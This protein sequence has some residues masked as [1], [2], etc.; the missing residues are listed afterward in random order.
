MP[1]GCR[2][3]GECCIFFE[4]RGRFP[5]HC[6]EN[7]TSSGGAGPLGMA[8]E[9][10]LRADCKRCQALCCIALSFERSSWF[11]FDKAADVPCPHLLTT[12]WTCSIHS[13]LE[14]RGQSGC[15]VYDCYG[16][17]QR[18]TQ[19]LP[20]VRATDGAG[21]ARRLT[22]AFRTLRRVHEQR[23][24]LHTAGRLPLSAEHERERTRLLSELEPTHMTEQTLE[25]LDL[26]TLEAAVRRL[27]RQFGGYVSPRRR[28]PLAAPPSVPICPGSSRHER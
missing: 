13:E 20:G 15:A 2:Q 23:L 5:A 17:G 3:L 11:A 18:V 9:R 10:E 14:A 6:R 28:L 7:A 12:T 16:A 4:V 24:L 21:Q 25:E 1:R 22:Q 26:A 8:H 27:L 19:L